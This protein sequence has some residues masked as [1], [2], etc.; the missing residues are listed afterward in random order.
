MAPPTR[1]T[2]RN[3]LADLAILRDELKRFCAEHASD[4]CDVLHAAR[5]ELEHA[6]AELLRW[7]VVQPVDHVLSGLL[8]EQAMNERRPAVL[9]RKADDG[10]AIGRGR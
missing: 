10:V 6:P 7:N 1:V 2:I 9:D 4:D 3:D 5:K 8:R